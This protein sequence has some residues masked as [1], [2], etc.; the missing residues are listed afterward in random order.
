MMKGRVAGMDQES[1]MIIGQVHSGPIS[2]IRYV[3]YVGGTYFVAMLI[4]FAYTGFQLCRRAR[5]TPYFVLTLFLCLPIIVQPFNFI[6]IFGSYD[7]DLPEAILAAGILKMLRNT[8]DRHEA[9]T[10]VVEE[11][12]ETPTRLKTQ[13]RFGPVRRPELVRRTVS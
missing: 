13:R 2:A 4:I 12:P 7:Y 10:A 6:F 1:F 8:L 5:G 9:L 3:G 11:S